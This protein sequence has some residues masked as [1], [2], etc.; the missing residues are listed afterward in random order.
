MAYSDC[1]ESSR[2]YMSAMYATYRPSYPPAM[3]EYVS[4]YVQQKV[5]IP[6]NL[7]PFCGTLR[8]FQQTIPRLPGRASRGLVS[9]S[10]F[11]FVDLCCRNENKFDIV[12]NTNLE[13][14]LQLNRTMSTDQVF[15]QE[16]HTEPDP[17]LQLQRE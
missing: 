9:Q 13:D 2:I 17:V 10:A 15:Y 4:K 14:F 7:L 11:S 5:R 8:L 12:W 1:F 6:V 16:N 3:F